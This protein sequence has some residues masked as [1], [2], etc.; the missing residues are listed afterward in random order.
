MALDLEPQSWVPTC[1]TTLSET[2]ALRRTRPEALPGFAPAEVGAVP[3]DVPTRS[4]SPSCARE[5]GVT[6]GVWRLNAQEGKCFVA[7]RRTCL[8]RSGSNAR[9][10]ASAKPRPVYPR[11]G[12][13]DRPRDSALDSCRHHADY[14]RGRLSQSVR[15][16][17]RYR[18]S[19][20]ARRRAAAQAVSQ[21]C[22]EE[23]ASPTR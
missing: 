14:L 6:S 16:C 15:V 9:V 23:G 7:T 10:S 17:C 3:V 20:A 18:G 2:Y 1:S 19:F 12:S 8:D 21:R 4:Q 13:D 22:P 5:M 11:S